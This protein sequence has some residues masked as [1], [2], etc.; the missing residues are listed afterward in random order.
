MKKIILSMFV[1]AALASCGG[2][3]PS[4]DANDVCDCNIKANAMKA[5]DPKR[6]EEI[7]KCTDMNMDMYTKYK[8]DLDGLKEYNEAIMECSKKVMEESMK[9]L[10]G[11]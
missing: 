4:K 6:P 11:E 9:N 5:D 3:D 1:V 10:K 7:K 8:E 2:N